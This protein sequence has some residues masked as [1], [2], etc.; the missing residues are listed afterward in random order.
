MGVFSKNMTCQT[1]T[2]GISTRKL[3]AYQF[4]IILEKKVAKSNQSHH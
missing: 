4:V 1:H 3:G 2:F